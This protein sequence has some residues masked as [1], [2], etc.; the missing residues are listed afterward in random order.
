[1][2][3]IPISDFQSGCLKWLE[4]VNQTGEP[5]LITHNDE[6]LVIVYPT[7]QKGNRASFGIAKET[8]TILSDII[9]PATTENEWET[10]G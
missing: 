7:S 6:P 10:L 3:K 5:L 4:T 9:E 1:M 2:G 8:A